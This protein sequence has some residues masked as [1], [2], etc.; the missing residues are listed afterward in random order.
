MVHGIYTYRPRASLWAAPEV[1]MLWECGRFC[2]AENKEFWKCF[3]KERG[4]IKWRPFVFY[5]DMMRVPEGMRRRQQEAAA[6]DNNR[7]QEE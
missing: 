5:E 4:G 1:L 2:A 7:K 6:Q 3:E